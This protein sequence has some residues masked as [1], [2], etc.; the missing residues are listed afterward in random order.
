MS[1]NTLAIANTAGIDAVD[2]LLQS[3]FAL[4]KEQ[5][6]ICDVAT[7]LTGLD[8]VQSGDTFRL[9]DGSCP[10]CGHETVKKSV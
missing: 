8:V 7:A 1:N 2:P 3:D 5:F 9:E 4:A 6:D 10:I